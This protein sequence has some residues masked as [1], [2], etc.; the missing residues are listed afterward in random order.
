MLGMYAPGVIKKVKTKSEYVNRQIDFYIFIRTVRTCWI[1]LLM[2][3][4]IPNMQSKKL[5][6]LRYMV[7]I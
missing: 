1:T 2:Q 7:N 5:L 6:L 4:H 3:A